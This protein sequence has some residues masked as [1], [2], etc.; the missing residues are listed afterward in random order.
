MGKIMEGSNTLEEDIASAPT[1][2]AD[3]ATTNG[4]ASRK[5]V[6]RGARP[7]SVSNIKRRDAWV[8]GTRRVLRAGSADDDDTDDND[9]G[10]TN[11]NG[12]DDSNDDSDDNDNDNGGYNGSDGSEDSASDEATPDDVT[13]RTE[14][15]VLFKTMVRGWRPGDLSL[16]PDSV[17]RLCHTRRGFAKRSP[18]KEQPL[19]RS[20][21]V[22]RASKQ[23]VGKVGNGQFM[24]RVVTGDPRGKTNTKWT[25]DAKSQSELASRSWTNGF[26]S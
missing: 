16:V 2:A 3:P 24:F 14:G 1:T 15:K 7:F 4:G 23:Y 25:L 9:G 6:I 5:P 10:G 18:C 12:E 11:D 17:L 22:V 20:S 21:E 13:F 8:A 19:D 26:L